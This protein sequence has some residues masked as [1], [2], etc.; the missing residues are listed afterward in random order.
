MHVLCNFF[1]CHYVFKKPSAGEASESVYMRERIKFETVHIV[2]TLTVNVNRGD[3]GSMVETLALNK[4]RL[5][6]RTCAS[7]NVYNLIAISKMI[8]ERGFAQTNRTAL[9]ISVDPNQ[10]HLI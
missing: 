5:W 2:V 3:S 10:R 1:F 4:N 8:N 9:T 6:V 7:K